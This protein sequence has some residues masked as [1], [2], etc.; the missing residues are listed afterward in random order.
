MLIP[1]QKIVYINI[2]THC[3]ASD[4]G[5]WFK[6]SVQR[7]LEQHHRKHRTWYSQLKMAL[8]RQELSKR[9][10]ACLL[11]KPPR[12]GQWWRCCHVCFLLLW[13]LATRFPMP[14]STHDPSPVLVQITSGLSV[15]NRR[16]C[17]VGKIFLRCAR[18]SFACCSSFFSCVWFG[19]CSVHTHR[20]GQTVQFASLAALV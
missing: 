1:W 16:D 15:W 5:R 4:D 10:P 20:L 3:G 18:D 7:S 2:I 12:R 17:V 13:D 19:S 9:M 6:N 14:T 11:I 8:A